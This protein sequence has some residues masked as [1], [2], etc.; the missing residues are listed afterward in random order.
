[1]VYS[2]HEGGLEEKEAVDSLVSQLP[3]KEY[4]VLMY[5]FINQVNLPP[6]LYIVEKR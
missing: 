5:K 6:Y 3:Q 1:M 2:G 4:N